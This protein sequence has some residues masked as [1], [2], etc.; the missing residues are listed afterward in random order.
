M[1]TNRTS[2]KTVLYILLGALVIALL[3]FAIFQ[4][5]RPAAPNTRDNRSCTSPGDGN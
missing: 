5:T 4:L 2:N 3:G 1:P